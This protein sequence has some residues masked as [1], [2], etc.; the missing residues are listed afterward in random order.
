MRENTPIGLAI[1]AS[2]TDF[3][4]DLVKLVVFIVPRFPS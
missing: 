4:L 2:T 3:G 1:H